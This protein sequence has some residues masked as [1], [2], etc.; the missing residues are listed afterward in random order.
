MSTKALAI[1]VG[2]GPAPGINAVIAAATIEARN[3]ADG[4]AY[5]VEKNLKEH[6]DKIEA[7]LK[8]RVEDE[9]KAVREALKGEDTPAITAASERLQQ[10]WHEAAAAMYQGAGAA[11]GGAAGTGAGAADNPAPGSAEKKQGGGGAVD[12]DF[13][14]VN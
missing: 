3:R 2:G 12:A 6:G 9:L 13:E 1:L 7:G 10:V 8:S 5:E 14:V 11:G 4:L